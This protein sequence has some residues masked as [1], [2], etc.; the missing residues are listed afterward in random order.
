MH[1]YVLLRRQ[2]LALLQS[3]WRQQP[4]WQSELRVSLAVLLC[5]DDGEVRQ[6]ALQHWDGVLQPTMARRM[7]VS[8]LEHSVCVLP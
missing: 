7:T 1:F 5:D 4:C 2:L 6:C 3:A 8:P